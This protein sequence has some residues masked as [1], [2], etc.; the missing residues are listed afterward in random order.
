MTNTRK[1]RYSILEKRNR[2]SE[3]VQNDQQARSFDM[4]V[5]AGTVYIICIYVCV[6]ASAYIYVCV[7]VRSYIYVCVRT[8]ICVRVLVQLYGATRPHRAHCQGC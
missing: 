1:G 3:R 4:C 7:R 6:R 8:C 2:F 5:Y